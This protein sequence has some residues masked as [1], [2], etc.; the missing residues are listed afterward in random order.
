MGKEMCRQFE[1]EIHVLESRFFAASTS[2][3]TNEEENKLEKYNQSSHRDEGS[4]IVIEELLIELEI[5]K[6]RRTE[7]ITLNQKLCTSLMAQNG[8]RSSFIS[9][10]QNHCT[11]DDASAAQKEFTYT[12]DDTT[13]WVFEEQKMANELRMANDLAEWE[14]DRANQAEEKLYQTISKLEEK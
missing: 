12:K 5:A 14:T 9:E 7:S 8:S 1:L 6:K 11:N 13:D 4:K 3:T 2:N 10:A